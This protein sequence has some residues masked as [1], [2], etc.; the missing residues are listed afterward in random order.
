[1]MVYYHP[2]W[3]QVNNWKRVLESHPDINFIVHAEELEHDID[4]LMTKYPNIYFTAN[5]QFHQHFK[6][7]VGKS[8]EEFLN[9]AEKDF[10]NLITKDLERW[11]KVIEKH[12]DR[13]MWGTDRGDAVWNYDIDVGLF[14]VKYGR[15]FIGR[16]DPAVQEK[17]GYKNAERLLEVRKN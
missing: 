4:E 1:M 9:A 13:F 3:N 17:V 10:E 11:E 6:L 16:L 12:P 5:P 7:Y 8:K 14:L 15:A 2:G